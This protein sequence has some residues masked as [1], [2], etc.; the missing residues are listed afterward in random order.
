M[1]GRHLFIG[2]LQGCL[3]AFERLLAVLHFRAGHDRLYLAGD[4][5]NR[6]G[7]S[8]AVLQRV[9]ELR[10][11]T[12]VVLGNH[13]LHLLAWARKAARPEH[14]EFQTILDHADGPALLAW[15][16][17]QPLLWMDKAAQLVM[18]HAGVD[19]RWGP[20]QA[21][22]H[23]AE[24]EQA[25]RDR[26]AR[27]FAHMYGNEPARWTA[28]LAPEFRLR[29]LVNVFTRMRFCREDGTLALAASGPP[30][31]APEGFA[32]WFDHLH[33][34][35]KGWKLIFGHWSQ[36]GLMYSDQLVCLDSGC[37]WG[38]SLTALVL[39]DHQGRPLANEGRLV[40]VSC[41]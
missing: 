32:P 17:R 38:G 11:V 33:P 28:D 5:V 30:E 22:Q 12:T 15:L 34:D 7:Q 39:P 10:E 8:L 19:P 27:F 37:V 23:A 24:V 16:E 21:R 14:A 35:W 18:V 4:L 31:Q 13:D 9:Y 29:T 1:S 25:L 2:D 20:V 26:P 3:D 36:L 6:G 40:S 41:A